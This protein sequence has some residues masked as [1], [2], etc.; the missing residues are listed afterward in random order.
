METV[1]LLEKYPQ[2]KPLIGIIGA[3]GFIILGW[4]GAAMKVF[5][6][7]VIIF[8]LYYYFYITVLKPRRDRILNEISNEET[9]E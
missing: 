7:L 3:I 6:G 9:E 8:C 4:G 5:W 2:L 1:N